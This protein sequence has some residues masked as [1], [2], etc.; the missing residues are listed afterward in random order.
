MF[1]C[2]DS[3]N[4]SGLLDDLLNASNINKITYPLPSIQLIGAH[5]DKRQAK[6]REVMREEWGMLLAECLVELLS[7]A[8][9]LTYVFF[10][11]F[12]HR[13]QLTERLGEPDLVIMLFC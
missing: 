1:F 7:R 9:F 11:F 6:K 13:L 4:D 5:R 8:A 3:G 2:H 10:F 12:L